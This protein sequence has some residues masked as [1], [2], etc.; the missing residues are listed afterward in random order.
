MIGAADLAAARL[1]A[2]ATLASDYI[3]LRVA[4]EQQQLLARTVEGYKRALEITQNQYH[5]GVVAKA[6]VITAQTQLEGAQSQLIATGVT[7]AT[8]EHAIAV[9]IGKA[10]ADFSLPP[11]TLAATVPVVPTGLPS[12]LLERRP[13][14]AAAE[15]RMAA[16]NAQ[17]GVAIAAY[18]PDLTLSGQY[19]FANTVAS[20]LVHAGVPG[21]FW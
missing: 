9:L 18:F 3:Q 21:P 14:V 10:P 20:G 5:V 2:E 1:S 7:R 15:R 6:D 4:D 16:A 8:L 11:A 13:D 19:G 17:V 12:S